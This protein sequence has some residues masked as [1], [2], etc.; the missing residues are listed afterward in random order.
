MGK[1]GMATTDGDI[2]HSRAFAVGIAQSVIWVVLGVV[3]LN[4]VPNFDKIFRD[5]NTKLPDMTIAVLNFGHFLSR[6]WYLALLPVLLWPFVNHGV[7]ALLSP[8]PEVVIPKRLWYFATWAIILVVIMFAVVAL[9]VPLIGD[10]QAI[11]ASPV[12]P[13]PPR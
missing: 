2:F 12:P 9:F 5:F 7:V 11:S 6:Y 13:G 10:I 3:A 4:V 8:R 1:H